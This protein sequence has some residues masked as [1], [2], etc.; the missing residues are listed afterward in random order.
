MAQKKA[1]DSDKAVKDFAKVEK[2]RIAETKADQL[3]AYLTAAWSVKH[4]KQSASAVA[5]QEK[6]DQGA[7]NRMVALLAPNSNQTRARCQGMSQ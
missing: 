3:A 4:K 5:K 6:L 1:T 7:L 2:V